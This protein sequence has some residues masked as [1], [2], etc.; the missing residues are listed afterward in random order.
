[1]DLNNWTL[2]LR[3]AHM[4]WPIV[5]LR[6]ASS[7]AKLNLRP[8]AAGPFRATCSTFCPYKIW[9]NVGKTPSLFVLYTIISAILEK[10]VEFY[11]PRLATR[12]IIYVSDDVNN[13]ILC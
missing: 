3:S 7:R 2:R 11:K 6:P 8:V 12:R 1:M 10:R 9:R 4:L 13:F 5:K